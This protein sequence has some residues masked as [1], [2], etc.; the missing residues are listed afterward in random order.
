MT[1]NDRSKESKRIQ[2]VSDDIFR[3]IIAGNPPK[4]D[5]KQLMTGE[6]VWIS[7]TE[8]E[9]LKTPDEDDFDIWKTDNRPRV[10]IGSRN[11]GSEIWHVQTVQ[12]QQV[13]RTL[14]CRR[15]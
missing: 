1:W 3:K 8:K 11:S 15:V 4:F 12:F 14:V 2:F 10:T 13:L 5:K 6:K 7:D 9:K